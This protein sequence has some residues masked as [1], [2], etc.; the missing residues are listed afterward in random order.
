MLSALLSAVP[1]KQQ[2]SLA[3]T[4]VPLTAATKFESCYVAPVVSPDS[5]QRAPSYMRA[6][7]RTRFVI[8]SLYRH[9]HQAQ[10]GDLADQEFLS[11]NALIGQYG[12][13]GNHNQDFPQNENMLIYPHLPKC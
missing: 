12:W 7:P 13:A 11:E 9:Q 3:V 2:V 6:V 8:E 10:T 5:V 4:F 1:T